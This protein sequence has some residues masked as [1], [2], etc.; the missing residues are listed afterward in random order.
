M[1]A[2]A[3][4]KEL[5]KR[6]NLTF[7]D[8]DEKMLQRDIKQLW[9]IGVIDGNKPSHNILGRTIFKIADVKFDVHN[10]ERQIL[11]YVEKSKK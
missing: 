9:M 6:G 5:N 1:K 2:S 11:Y 10:C 7:L 4:A 3:L 8:K